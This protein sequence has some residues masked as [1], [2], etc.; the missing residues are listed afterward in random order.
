MGVQDLVTC[1]RPLPA[2]S[3]LNTV[4]VGS[5]VRETPTSPLEGQK[6]PASPL[7]GQKTAASPRGTEDPC[8]PLEGRSG[9][10]VATTRSRLQVMLLPGREGAGQESWAPV[11]KRWRMADEAPSFH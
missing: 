2:P 5:L 8:L 6:T 1:S 3:Y 11:R 4:P 7:E 9:G 10:A